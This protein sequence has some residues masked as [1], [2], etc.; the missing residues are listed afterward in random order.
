[1]NLKI[2]QHLM[3]SSQEHSLEPLADFIMATHIGLFILASVKIVSH[4]ICTESTHLNLLVPAQSS[5]HGKDY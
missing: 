5:V 4:H 1:M 3:G 2:Q